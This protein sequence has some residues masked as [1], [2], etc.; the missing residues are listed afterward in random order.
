MV[1][2]EG[3]PENDVCILDGIVEGGGGGDPFGQA[4]G[5]EAGGLGNVPAGGVELVVC[6]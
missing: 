5:G 6:V 4:A 1:E 2:A 3:V